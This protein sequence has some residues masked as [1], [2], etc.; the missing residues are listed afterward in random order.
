MRADVHRAFTLIEVLVVVA[1]I[2]IAAAVTLPR[3]TGNEARA[4]RLA[5]EDVADLFTMF[6]HRESMGHSNVALGYD[7]ES[8]T[9]MLL[10]LVGDPLNP[11]F[12]PH[13]EIDRLEK[14]VALPDLLSIGEVREDGVRVDRRDWFIPVMPGQGRPAIELVLVS[15]QFTATVVL[16]RDGI[17]AH[18]VFGD[19]GA[20]VRQ[21]I[22]LDRQGRSEE[23]W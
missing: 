17:A 22:D 3:L 18:L 21:T 16:P 13:W 11:D 8:H 4:A 23:I 6:A 12:P 2:A 7:P 1:V 14:P 5:A 15:E 20:T 9:L 10:R 19:D